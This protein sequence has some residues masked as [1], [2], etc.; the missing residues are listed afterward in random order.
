[1]KWKVQREVPFLPVVNIEHPIESEVQAEW[2][3]DGG[4]GCGGGATSGDRG[5]G[6]GCSDRLVEGRQYRHHVSHI[7][8][9]VILPSQA[10][11]IKRLYGYVQ[12]EV[13]D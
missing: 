10:V 6:G 1:M 7:K 12:V 11:S 5:P 4:G 8:Q 2:H 9:L 3:V 13:V